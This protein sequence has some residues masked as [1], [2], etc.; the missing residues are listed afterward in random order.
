[1][2]DDIIQG[3]YNVGL[4]SSSPIRRRVYRLICD[5]ALRALKAFP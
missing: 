5:L 1:M 4:G 3:P 2:R